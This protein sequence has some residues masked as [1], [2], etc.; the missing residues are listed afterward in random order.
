MP[1]RYAPNFTAT[2][3][4]VGWATHAPTSLRLIIFQ[5]LDLSRLPVNNLFIERNWL[6]EIKAVR[7]CEKFPKID[8]PRMGGCGQRLKGFSRVF[9]FKADHRQIT[10]GGV[11]KPN[12][13][14]RN[15]GGLEN[16]IISLLFITI[17]AFQSCISLALPGRMGTTKQ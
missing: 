14:T 10:L 16:R 8:S 15:T 1:G 7:F 12:L 2:P 3:A 13:L 11:L 9:H 4:S 6:G 17:R 5:P